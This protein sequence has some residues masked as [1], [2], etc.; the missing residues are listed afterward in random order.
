MKIVIPTVVLVLSFFCFRLAGYVPD[1]PAGVQ[2]FR[3]PPCGCCD[4]GLLLYGPG[5]CAA[6]CMPLIPANEGLTG[7]VDDWMTPMFKDGALGMAYPKLIYPVF[8]MGVLFSGFLLFSGIKGKSLNVFL[9]GIL[10]ILSLYGFKNQLWG[11]RY[12]LTTSYK[13]LFTPISFIL[14]LGPLLYFYTKS[15]LD[16]IFEWKKRYWLHF[17]P[18]FAASLSYGVLLFMPG[19]VQRQFMFSPFE[20][21]FS[22]VEQVAAVMAGFIYLMLARR[23]YK[24]WKGKTEKA[25]SALGAWVSRFLVGQ[26]ALFIFWALVILSN[27][28]LYDFGVA[29]VT[30]N[31][32]WVFIGVILLWL[33]VEITSNPRLFLIPKPVL[34]TNGNRWTTDADLQDHGSRL[35]TLMA[36]QKLYVDQDLSLDKLALVMEVNPRYLSAVLNNAVGKNFYEFVNYYRIEEVKRLLLSP[37]NGHLTI[38]AIANQAGFKSKSTFN[39]AFKKQ[40]GMT[41]REFLKGNLGKIN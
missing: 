34:P 33:G 31:P 5:N 9:N 30:Y 35:Q 4:D 38:E 18:A 10:L 12:G 40:T 3:C 19:Q 14:L 7:T 32:L 23:T 21:S 16:P 15:I 2:K 37:D 20:V 24:R 26:A 6:C 29:T 17:I 27:F 36:G 39:A 11:V 13:S 25:G 22:H 28:W 41:P 8:A 1:T